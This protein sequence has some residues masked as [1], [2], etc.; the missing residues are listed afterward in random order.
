M[1]CCFDGRG[2]SWGGRGEVSW[3]HAQVVAHSVAAASFAES[4]VGR[5]GVNPW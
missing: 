1:S 5:L 2:L 4:E 3:E